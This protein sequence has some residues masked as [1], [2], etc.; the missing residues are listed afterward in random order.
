VTFSQLTKIVTYWNTEATSPKKMPRLQQLLFLASL[1]LAL[2]F[3]PKDVK[4]A[5]KITI[6][7]KGGSQL[8]YIKSKD[9][10]PYS[11]SLPTLDEDMCCT[12]KFAPS[13][14][15]K[16]SRN[17]HQSVDH[18]SASDWLYNLKTWK[19]SSVLR[20]I[21]HPVMYLS[22]W[23]TLLSIVQ[24]ILILSGKKKW[25]MS[26]CIPN[27]A[28]SFLVSSLGLLLVFRT[29]S[30]YQ[31]FLVRLRSAHVHFDKPTQAHYFVICII[32][33]EGR[34]IWEQVLTV[35]RNFS[36]LTTLYQNEVGSERRIRIQNLLAAFPYLL[37]HHVRSGCLCN[38]DPNQIAG[39]NLFL[40]DEPTR[41]EKRCWV[42]R[43]NLPWS[44]IEKAQHSKKEKA[45][46]KIGQ[47]ANR[48]LWICDRIGQEIMGI[49][50]T[51]NFTSRERL[52]LLGDIDKL[53]N[54]VGSCERIHQTAVPLH[55]ARHALRSLT[56][57]I[58]TLPLS[59]VNDFGLLT[60]PVTAIVAWLLFGVYQIGHSIE[61][62]FQ[63]SLQLSVMCDDIRR[64]ILACDDVRQSAFYLEDTNGTPSIEMDIFPKVVH[65]NGP[66][67]LMPKTSKLVLANGELEVIGMKKP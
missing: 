52:K 51:P 14:S 7:S 20:E 15:T 43:T 59:L 56:V 2:A 46:Q 1:S 25:A 26:F 5:S 17:Q 39:Q 57:W 4:T 18:H 6:K 19:N 67:Q 21:K 23:A 29:N 16:R 64:D 50:M 30:A 44:L 3:S 61:D 24:K 36:R 12:N 48:P 11:P 45:L 41:P 66:E 58:V 10:I 27:A 49:P 34:K 33:Q 13:T 65:D 55:Y 63:G 38:N 9:S 31:R 37:R 32:L 54:A 8:Q 47:V 35:S 60:G 28:H 40:L 22:A 53:A 62:P 42:D